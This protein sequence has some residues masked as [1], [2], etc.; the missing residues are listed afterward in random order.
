MGIVKLMLTMSIGNCMSCKYMSVCLSSI[1][2]VGSSA[3]RIKPSTECVPTL[4]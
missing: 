3:S 4:E 2:H 1:D